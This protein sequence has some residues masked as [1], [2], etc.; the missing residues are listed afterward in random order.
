MC[1][2]RL[3]ALVLCSARCFPA[4]IGAC[5]L[6]ALRDGYTCAP[7]LKLHELCDL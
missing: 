1:T 3:S 5:E 4:L 6:A 2:V 7:L